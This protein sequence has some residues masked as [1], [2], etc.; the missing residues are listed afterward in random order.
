MA[1][2]LTKRVWLKTHSQIAKIA[3]YKVIE[4]SEIKEEIKFRAD[5][6]VS[7]SDKEEAII[8]IEKNCHTQWDWIETKD[9]GN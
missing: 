4:R 6:S 8:F 7:V 3:K 9:Q 5:F 1:T 2:P